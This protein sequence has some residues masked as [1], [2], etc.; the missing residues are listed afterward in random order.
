[1]SILSSWPR[2]YNTNK[3]IQGDEWL[4]TGNTFATEERE[5]WALVP[6]VRKTLNTLFETVSK[7]F[8]DH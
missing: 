1:M 5:K 6:I 7:L 8:K 3:A 4:F 2:E